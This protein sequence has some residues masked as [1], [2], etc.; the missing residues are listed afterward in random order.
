MI[1]TGFVDSVL[2]RLRKALPASGP[3]AGM[4]EPE[5]GG[6]KRLINPPSR[7]VLGAAA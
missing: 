3:V 7:A 4:H 5:S 1:D 6:K 2:E